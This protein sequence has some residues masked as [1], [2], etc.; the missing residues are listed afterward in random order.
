MQFLAVSEPAMPA[1]HKGS[2]NNPLP[3]NSEFSR[4]IEF[5]TISEN[6]RGIE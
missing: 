1:D 2:V 5:N 3:P 4:T 6:R